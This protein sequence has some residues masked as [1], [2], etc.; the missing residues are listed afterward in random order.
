MFRGLEGFRFGYRLADSQ[1][2]PYGKC[3]EESPC[4]VQLIGEI[5][6]VRPV[7]VRYVEEGQRIVYRVSRHVNGFEEQWDR[8]VVIPLFIIRVGI[9]E[10]VE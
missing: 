8:A 3:P 4:Q 9:G 10:L 5:R 6:V 1:C 2:S 7:G